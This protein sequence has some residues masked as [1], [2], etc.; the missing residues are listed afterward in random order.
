MPSDAPSG[1]VG[2]S[3]FGSSDLFPLYRCGD[4]HAEVLGKRLPYEAGS[5]HPRTCALVPHL[6]RVGPTHHGRCNR[7]AQRSG[8]HDSGISLT[9]VPGHATTMSCLSAS[10]V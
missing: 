5:T 6:A 3:I 4:I 10:S 7:S 1:N 9:L 8:V 2:R